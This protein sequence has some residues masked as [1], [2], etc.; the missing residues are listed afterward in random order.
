MKNEK[1]KENKDSVSKMTAGELGKKFLDE[2]KAHGPKKGT[3]GDTYHYA[4]GWFGSNEII[5]KAAISCLSDPMW[6]FRI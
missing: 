6:S 3:K 4:G 2:L 5:R 1:K